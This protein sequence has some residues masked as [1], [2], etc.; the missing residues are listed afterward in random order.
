MLGYSASYATIQ[1]GGAPEA[2]LFLGGLVVGALAE[3]LARLARLP[4]L[5]FVIPGF[6]SLVPG[7]P[8]FLT[9]VSFA[10]QDYTGGLARLVETTLLIATLA[11]GI[12]VPNALTRI[13]QPPL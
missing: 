2:A 3:I 7:I 1:L 11:A 6:I 8:A 13:R 5:I 9:V 12:G 4:A 10:S